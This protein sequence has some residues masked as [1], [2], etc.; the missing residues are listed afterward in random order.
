MRVTTGVTCLLIATAMACAR[1][2]SEETADVTP[3]D[4]PGAVESRSGTTFAIDDAKADLGERVYKSKG[5]Q[6]CHTIGKGKSAGPDLAGVTSRR[7]EEW[8]RRWLKDPPAMV[9]TD[10]IAKQMLQEYNNVVMPKMN[11]TDQEIENLLHFMA[12]ESRDGEG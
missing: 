2:T 5:C 10:P 8:L 4:T 3:S 12:R 9:Q 11:L 6:S 1:S 7:D